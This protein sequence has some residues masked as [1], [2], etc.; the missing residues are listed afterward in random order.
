MRHNGHKHAYKKTKS[1]S[2]PHE[3]MGHLA[4]LKHNCDKFSLFLNHDHVYGDFQRNSETHICEN[5]LVKIQPKDCLIMPLHR[6]PTT[7][8]GYY[9]RLRAGTAKTDDLLTNSYSSKPDRRSVSYVTSFGLQSHSMRSHIRKSITQTDVHPFFTISCRKCI[10]ALGYLLSQTDVN[11]IGESYKGHPYFKMF[12]KH[13]LWLLHSIALQSDRA[14]GKNAELNQDFCRLKNTIIHKHMKST[15]SDTKLLCGS[16]E[17]YETVEEYNCILDLE[18]KTWADLAGNEI[19]EFVWVNNVSCQRVG[20]LS[21]TVRIRT[22]SFRFEPKIHC[23]EEVLHKVMKMSKPEVMLCQDITILNAIY[24]DPNGDSTFIRQVV[25]DDENPVSMNFQTVN[26]GLMLKENESNA[27]EGETASAV[28]DSNRPCSLIGFLFGYGL[29]MQLEMQGDFSL[30]NEE[31]IPVELTCASLLK[32]SERLIAHLSSNDGKQETNAITNIKTHLLP[33]QLPDT[34][35]R[36]TTI[37]DSMAKNFAKRRDN[38]QINK[39]EILQMHPESFCKQSFGCFVQGPVYKDVLI[40][41][42]ASSI[43]IYISIGKP[44]VTSSAPQWDISL[45]KDG[46]G[47]L[48]QN[49]EFRIEDIL[50]AAS[51]ISIFDNELYM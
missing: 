22:Y 48:F 17:V 28:A 34:A 51:Q 18:N 31:D 46:G 16:C 41:N 29:P 45:H 2:H 37:L 15:S 25:D 9:E 21:A 49:Q 8:R 30:H 20:K 26:R 32:A 7:L 38:K 27:Q 6:C 39:N 40:N 47:I 4:A 5:G 19:N 12:S 35:D 43:F 44:D 42:R 3:R 23:K 14:K 10:P 36:K 13:C 33:F 24:S 50:K 1:F 11:S